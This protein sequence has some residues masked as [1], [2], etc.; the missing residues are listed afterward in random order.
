MRETLAAEGGNILIGAFTPLATFALFHMVTVFPLSWVYLTT[1]ERSP[2][3]SASRSAPRS[4]GL[5]ADHRLRRARRPRSAGG[6]C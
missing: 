6:G 4:L 3:F 5:A 2:A 1:G